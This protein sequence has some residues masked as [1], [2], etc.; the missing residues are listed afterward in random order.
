[1][2]GLIYPLPSSSSSH[3][4]RASSSLSG[5]GYSLQSMVSGAS[6]FK[7][8]AW[9]HGREGGN[10]FDSTGSNMFACLRYSS[11]SSTSCV[12][13]P[14]SLDSSIE[15]P[16]RE[17]SLSSSWKMASF[18]RC[19]VRILR[20]W[21]ILAIMGLIHDFLQS[22][23]RI[24]MGRKDVSMEVSLHLNLGSNVESQGILR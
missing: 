21:T 7:V 12:N 24:M 8:I 17:D 3:F 9:S 20:P 22:T 11:G 1:M 10:F 14:A 2:D 18:C 13:L 19:W 5:N 4:H 15:I 6:G 16:L 23:E